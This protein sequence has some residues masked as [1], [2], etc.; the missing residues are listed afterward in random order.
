MSICTEQVSSLANTSTNQP[1]L[2]IVSDF[3]SLLGGKLHA[4]VSHEVSPSKQNPSEEEMQFYVYLLC[5]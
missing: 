1:S 4:H 2:L 3:Y 5:L